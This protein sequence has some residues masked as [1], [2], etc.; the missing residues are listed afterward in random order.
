M[1]CLD[2]IGRNLA[3]P[4]TPEPVQDKDVSLPQIIKIK[5][6]HIL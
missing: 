1:A 5:Y 2:K 3:L 4:G 6:S